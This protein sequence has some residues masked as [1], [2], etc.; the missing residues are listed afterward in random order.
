MRIFTDEA[1]N[2]VA[3]ANGQSLFSLVLALVVP[4]SVENDLFQAF[5][6]LRDRWPNNAVEIKGSK[7]DEAQAAQ[8]IE[9]VSR[10]DVFVKF[11]AAD[12]ATHGDGI[13]GPFKARQ[14]DAITAH[15]TPE[16]HPP[17]VA[18]LQNLADAIRRMPDQ[19]FLQAFLM[20]ELVLKVIEESTLYYVQRLPEELASIAWIIDQKNKT[21]TEMESTW[22][23]VILPM[24][25]NHF[26]RNPLATLVGADYSHFDAR[27]G[28]DPN[29][30]EMKRHLAWTREAYGI[31]DA[32]RPPGLNAGLLL[33]EQRQFADSASS[34]GLQLADML[35]TILRR[36]LNNRLQSPGWENYG[37]LLL[38][39]KS[40]TPLLQL[41]PAPQSG[42]TQILSGQQIEKVWRALVTGNKPMVLR[43]KP[44]LTKKVEEICQQHGIAI[45]WIE[46][47]NNRAN[48]KQKTI[49]INDISDSGSFAAALHEIGHVMRD[50]ESPPANEREKLDVETN[51]WQWA[52]QSNNN[53]FDA[54]GWNTLHHSL[55]QYYAAV[56]DTTHRAHD[57]LVR[58]EQ[59][60]PTIRSRV[61]G[62]GAPSLTS[63]PKKTTKPQP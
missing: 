58:A 20:I 52:L 10:Y 3:P 30:E 48:S 27:Y 1:C 32:D 18:Q 28:I 46:S 59:H 13:V 51:A 7:L 14:A 29:D 42:R 25:E 34:L 38:A 40:S 57:L 22:S 37:R 39:D 9:L 24:S 36:A 63:V 56:M 26:A 5:L 60:V 41:G 43:K 50:P 17:I 23:T 44:E 45:K 6:R 8:L 33:S 35:A 61:S 21:I 47:G 53:D 55:H 31:R 12:M 49:W 2:F 19:L 54:A 11:F 15:L 62:Y 16:H 4:S